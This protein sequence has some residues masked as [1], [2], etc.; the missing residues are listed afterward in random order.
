M[1]TSFGDFK[2]FI[3]LPTFCLGTALKVTS[4]Q[5]RGVCIVEVLHTVG[6][7]TLENNFLLRPHRLHSLDLSPSLATVHTITFNYPHFH[8][9]NYIHY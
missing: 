7:G 2:M 5:D 3:F 4:Q 1:N 8:L 9:T 6:M